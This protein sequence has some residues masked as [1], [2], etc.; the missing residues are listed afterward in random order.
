MPEEVY[1]LLYDIE[2]NNAQGLSGL[3]EAQKKLAADAQVSNT[4]LKNFEAEL[5]GAMATGRS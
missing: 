1:R 5:R 2:V 4:Q 3:S